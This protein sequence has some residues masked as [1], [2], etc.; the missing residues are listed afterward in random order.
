MNKAHVLLRIILLTLTEVLFIHQLMA[1]AF[2]QLPGPLGVYHISPGYSF[3]DTS[4]K[5]SLLEE[6]EFKFGELIFADQAVDHDFDFRSEVDSC[7]SWN[8]NRIFGIIQPPTEGGVYNQPADTALYFPYDIENGPGMIQGGHRFSTLSKLYGGYSGVILDDWNGDTSITR[9]VRD[10]VRGKYVDAN[11]NVY[12]DSIATTPE[13][14][15]YIVIYGT[16]ANPA[17]LPVIDGVSYW[18][19]ANQNCCYANLDTDVTQLRISY[20]HKEIFVGIYLRNSELGWTDPSGVQ[21]LLQHSLD[22]YD[23]GDINGITIFAGPRLNKDTMP[24]SEWKA[25]ALPFW[26]DSL[27]YPYLG[28][29]QG[30][31]SDCSTGNALPDAFV[32]VYCK[33]RVSG[34]TLIRSRQKTDLGGNYQCGLWAGN[35]QSDSTH[36]WLKAERTGYYTDTVGFWIKRGERTN[37]PS[38]SL[39]PANATGVNGINDSKNNLLIV[40]NPSNGIFTVE[41]TGGKPVKGLLE[42]YNVEGKQVYL[43]N[44]VTVHPLIDLSTQPDGIYLVKIKTRDQEFSPRQ[45]LVLQH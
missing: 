39:C 5:D 7:V 15:L 19:Y 14:K 25:F 43:T 45:I 12:S 40:P 2:N 10:A 6:Y 32:S 42:I 36:Y 1:Q 31:I 16:G 38:L 29:G 3:S 20:P 4:G 33:G 9:K 23:D 11:G 18:Y 41:L 28:E 8:A 30:K 17:A 22:R 21:Y 34:D 13:N 26:L 27:Y 37:I 24:L 44:L 35:R